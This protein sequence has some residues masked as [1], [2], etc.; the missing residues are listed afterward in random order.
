M[1]PNFWMT[2]FSR[3]ATLRGGALAAAGLGTAALVGCGGSDEGDEGG[4]A[5]TA[6]QG[7]GTSAPTSSDPATTPAAVGEGTYGGRIKLPILRPSLTDLD[8]HTS[9]YLAFDL[10]PYISNRAITTSRDGSELVPWLIDSWEVPGEGTEMTLKVKPGV[11]WHAKEPY[12]TG[13]DFDAEDLAFNLMRIAGKLDPDGNLALYQRRT[14]LEGMSSAEAI[15]DSTVRVVFDRPASPFLRGVSDHRNYMVPRDFEDNGG[16]FQDPATFVG[17]GPFMLTAFQDGTLTTMERHPNYWKEGLPYLDGIDF[18]WLADTQAQITALASGQLDVILSADKT[19]R[20]TLESLAPDVQHHSFEFGSWQHIRFQSQRPPF[21]DP[22]VR[23]A[24]R[25]VLDIQSMSDSVHGA[26]YWRMTGPAPQVFPEAYT[27]DEIGQM[28]GWNP[29]TKE[30][31]IAEAK[32]LMDAAGFADG[33]IEFKILQSSAS[34]TGATYEYSVLATDKMREVWPAMDAGLDVPTG[35]AS[36]GQ[37][38]ANGEFQALCYSI[39]PVPDLVLELQSHY[40]SDGSRNYGRY[41]S[42]E[43]D[44][45]LGQAFVELDPDARAELLVQVQDRL[46]EESPTAVLANPNMNSAWAPKVR[47]FESIGHRIRGGH[48][49]LM[50]GMEQVWFA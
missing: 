15:D 43:V 45:L 10:W 22:R 18:Q 23:R 41:S 32:K 26:G 11:K 36:F 39:F 24:L 4:A 6:T 29:D 2:R 3:R 19:A 17:T 16:D 31:D 47:N 7:G 13:R 14:T 48:Y 25:L 1:E 34:Q 50:N 49:D 9:L 27:A 37:L 12:N 42:T 30:Q 44:D 38:Q 8:P 35:D 5:T 46:I 21:D 40:Q 33:A 28:P 20:A